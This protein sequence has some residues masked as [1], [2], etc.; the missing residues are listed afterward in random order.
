MRGSIIVAAMAACSAPV[1]SSAQAAPAAAP[2]AD[3]IVDPFFDLLRRGQVPQALTTLTKGSP[4][5][6]KRIAD[7][8]ELP[9]QIQGAIDVYGTVLT[10]ERIDTKPLGTLL[11]RDT[12]LIQHRDYVTRWRFVYARTAAGWTLTSFV[13]D[14]QIPGWFD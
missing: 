12:W 5:L 6:G 2:A 8:G 7:A 13:F 10:W 14:D 9:K 11:R 4:L 3:P 1:A